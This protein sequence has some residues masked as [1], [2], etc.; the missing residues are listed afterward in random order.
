M[1]G[2]IELSCP[3]CR[4]RFR[5]KEAYGHLKG[6]CPV[7]SCGFRIHPVKPRPAESRPAI[8]HAEIDE[9]VGLLPLDDDEWPEPAILV[10][11]DEGRT[12]GVSESTTTIPLKD[13]PSAPASAEPRTIPLAPEPVS[14]Q[15]T[16]PARRAN[17]AP[18]SPP[19]PPPAAAA[20]QPVVEYDIL[21]EPIIRT[22]P[23]APPQPM[24]PDRLDRAAPSSSASATSAAPSPLVVEQILQTESRPSQ[25]APEE[26]D[27]GLYRL[28]DL[29]LDS[30]PA[31]TISRSDTVLAEIVPDTP[32][33]ADVGRQERA[34]PETPREVDS[35]SPYQLSDA[36]LDPERP[37]PVPLRLFWDGVWNFALRPANLPRLA[38]MTIGWTIVGVLIWLIAYC[39]SVSVLLGHISM[40]FGGLAALMAGLVTGGYASF[41]F[42][43]V[44]TE[45]ANGADEVEYPEWDTQAAALALL[46]IAW[47][48]GIGLY[49]PFYLLSQLGPGGQVLFVVLGP[50]ISSVV[51]LSVLSKDAWYW[52]INPEIL[53]MLRRRSDVI[54]PFYV[55]SM[56]IILLWIATNYIASLIPIMIPLA[57]AV[58]A[59]GWLTWARVLGRAGY[60]LTHEK[61]PK[62]RKKRR[63]KD[64]K[65]KSNETTS[66]EESVPEALSATQDVNALPPGQSPQKY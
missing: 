30:T 55:Y 28:A 42:L 43:H 18:V 46:R 8:R 63:K 24:T 40:V 17:P 20:N 4:A 47:L 27:I 2:W 50:L 52:V 64:G 61:L 45:T 7:P 35:Y 41:T 25:A 14:Q 19:K 62:R 1:E 53:S 56:V 44:L 66:A 60:A 15:K 54:P 57:A 38:V 32:A 21:G 13:T 51:I 48:F 36:E 6:R 23:T 22:M 10:D 3:Y 12:Y 37:P 29:P 39:Y 65:D 16:D 33:Q 11:R 49:L 26:P 31:R 9:P 5:I 59:A 58:F 34:K